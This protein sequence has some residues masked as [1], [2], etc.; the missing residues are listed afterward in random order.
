MAIPFRYTFF[1]VIV[2]WNFIHPKGLDLI[3]FRTRYSTNTILPYFLMKKKKKNARKIETPAKRIFPSFLQFES[4]YALLQHL[5][6]NKF[7]SKIPKSLLDN[8]RTLR[9]SDNGTT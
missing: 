6:N 5:C 2:Y 7:I 4:S 8:L 3:G 1:Y 9:N